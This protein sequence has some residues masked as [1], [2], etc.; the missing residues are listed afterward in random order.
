MAEGSKRTV[1]E[2]SNR[3]VAEGS[4]RTVA[5]GSKRTVAE[6]SVGSGVSVIGFPYTL[7]NDCQLCSCCRVPDD[8]FETEFVASIWLQRRLQC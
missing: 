8:V 3:T 2:G 1:A 6:G 7:V 4:K 5:E